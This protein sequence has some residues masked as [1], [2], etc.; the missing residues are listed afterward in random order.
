L[1]LTP[2]EISFAADSITTMSGGTKVLELNEDAVVISTGRLLVDATTGLT[3]SGAIQ[4]SRL[5][6]E[7]DNGAGLTIASVG[8]D[9]TLSATRGITLS[10]EA[11]GIAITAATNIEVATTSTDGAVIIDSS[12]LVVKSLGS[13]SIGGKQL[14]VCGDGTLYTVDASSLCNSVSCL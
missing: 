6:N 14:C 3:V 5:Q 2:S 12:S 4:S 7:R 11:S 9:L 10:S 13:G 8:Q 1:E